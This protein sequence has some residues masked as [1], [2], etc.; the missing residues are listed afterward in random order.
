M[1]Q[2]ASCGGWRGEE[3]KRRRDDDPVELDIPVG[4]EAPGQPYN[5]R[6]VVGRPYRHVSTSCPNVSICVTAGDNAGAVGGVAEEQDAIV[7]RI[8][9]FV[10]TE[11]HER[12]VEARALLTDIV[13]VGVVHERT[14]A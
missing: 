4:R 1:T 2:S 5:V 9:L 8:P 7:F 14:G 12:T 10:G 13:Q 6:S 11:H 3:Q